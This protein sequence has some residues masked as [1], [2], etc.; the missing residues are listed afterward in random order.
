V[1]HFEA[2]PSA[3]KSPATTISHG[4][5]RCPYARSARI[6]ATG[7]KETYTSLMACREKST[8][9]G[10]V[11]TIAAARIAAARLAPTIRTR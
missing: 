10:S 8:W 1:L 6:A 5:L 2:I 9:R 4:R 7:K 11:A 3:R